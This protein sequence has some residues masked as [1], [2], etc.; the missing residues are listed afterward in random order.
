MIGS[1][2]TMTYTAPLTFTPTVTLVGG[3]G[4]TVPVYSTNS[5]RYERI[6]NRVFV[7]IYLTG[8]GGNEGA[9]TG[10]LT[11]AI[12]LTASANHNT[13]YFTAGSVINGTEEQICYGVINGAVATV[14]LAM[15]ADTAGAV[16][17]DIVDVTG[18]DQNSTTR[19]VRL[20]FVYEV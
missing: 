19:S 8:D 14:S 7:D 20:K 16:G 3:A 10:V 6:G 11:V 12:P 15:Q 17:S 5:G 9:G 13:G 4:N 1:N 2:A 18:A